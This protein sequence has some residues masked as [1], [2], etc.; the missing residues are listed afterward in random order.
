MFGT[1][2]PFVV[3]LLV[4]V[5]TWTVTT[6]FADISQVSALMYSETRGTGRDS[7]AYVEYR[8]TNVSPRKHL[9]DFFVSIDCVDRTRGCF[10]E[11]EATNGEIGM[12]IT[13][14]PWSM[15]TNVENMGLSVRQKVDLPLDQSFVIRATLSSP[16]SKVVLLASSDPQKPEAI[17]G[18]DLLLT[19]SI[20]AELFI[21]RNYVTIVA[22]LWIAAAVILAFV[23]FAAR[24]PEGPKS[25][26]TVNVVISK[27]PP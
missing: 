17:R 9:A 15:T 6:F 3:T 24:R 22:V 5:L 4:S 10:Q 25:P 8:L 2:A 13:V 26:E 19:D 27:E 20:T 14:P 7:K 21:G 1:S 18:L 23:Y 16:D 12:T 11:G